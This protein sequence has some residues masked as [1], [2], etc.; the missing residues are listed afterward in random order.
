MSKGEIDLMVSVFLEYLLENMGCYDEY[1]SA[2]REYFK[3]IEA[4]VLLR[5]YDNV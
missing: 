1:V 2:L 5:L 3:V 4:R